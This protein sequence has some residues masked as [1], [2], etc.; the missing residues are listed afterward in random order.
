MRLQFWLV[1]LD[2][3]AFCGGFGSRPYLWAVEHAAECVD[4]V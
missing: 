2:A 3:I 4:G 1:V